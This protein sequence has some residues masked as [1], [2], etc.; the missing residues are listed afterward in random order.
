MDSAVRVAF[1][2]QPTASIIERI[3]ILYTPMI[4]LSTEKTHL[5]LPT[6]HSLPPATVWPIRCRSGDF[7]IE[8]RADVKALYTLIPSICDI[9]IIIRCDID[10][11]GA[12]QS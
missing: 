11:N 2:I 4:S 6:Q 3:F 10:A 12:V 7:G 8:R 5:C 9:D 1:L